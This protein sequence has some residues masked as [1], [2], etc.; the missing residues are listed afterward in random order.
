MK[1]FDVYR[2]KDMPE[3]WHFKQNSR[4]PPIFLMAKDGYAFQD[5]LQTAE[6]YKNENHLNSKRLTFQFFF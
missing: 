3:R 1:T 5:I 6:R 2:K 4:A